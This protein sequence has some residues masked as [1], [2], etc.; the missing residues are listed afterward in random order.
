MLSR[1]RQRNKEE[2][3]VSYQQEAGGRVCE[4]DSCHLEKTN[5][6]SFSSMSTAQGGEPGTFLLWGNSCTARVEGGIL[7]SGP[8]D[9]WAAASPTP[10]PNLY[11]APVAQ[12]QHLE[13][14]PPP[15]LL[16]HLTPHRWAVTLITPRS[17]SNVPSRA[18]ER[19][20]AS[21][22][23]KLR[24]KTCP[25]DIVNSLWKYMNPQMP[26]AAGPPNSC[27]VPGQESVFSSKWL[28]MASGNS[29]MWIKVEARVDADVRRC[30]RPT[31]A[32]GR[33]G[34]TNLSAHSCEKRGVR[35]SL[36]LWGHMQEE[37]HQISADSRHVTCHS[38]SQQK[39][40]IWT[41]KHRKTVFLSV[42]Q[43]TTSPDK[44]AFTESIVRY[45]PWCSYVDIISMLILFFCFCFFYH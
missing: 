19:L 12:V 7:K 8:S 2:T 18:K 27:A 45:Q 43:G 13:P 22:T 42:I 15:L 34:S 38:E 40:S 33:G 16:L 35:S 30:V 23:V 39:G 9:S 3:E 1:R 25:I 5:T 36:L 26:L 20:S 32:G 14:P 21:A 10:D 11:Q 29:G 41:N 44:C 31:V 28:N 24:L 37:L 17:Y 4:I 6:F